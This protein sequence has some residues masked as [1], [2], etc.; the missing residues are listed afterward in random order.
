MSN[1]E[2]IKKLVLNITELDIT[3]MI[4]SKL[5]K[6]AGDLAGEVVTGLARA[7]GIPLVAGAGDILG[8]TIKDKISNTIKNKSELV[9]KVETNYYFY[10]DTY[11]NYQTGNY[12]YDI[13]LPKDKF[14]PS[15]LI[16]IRKFIYPSFKRFGYNCKFIEKRNDSKEYLFILF[17]GNSKIPMRDNKVNPVIYPFPFDIFNNL[18]TEEDS[19]VSV[20]ELLKL[21]SIP[22]SYI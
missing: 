18:D 9:N 17:K 1:I 2:R 19:D 11:R 20:Y 4:K 5:K 16:R 7:S 8:N 13:D 15:E 10:H 3:D 12:G 21:F 14:N 6:T 22:I